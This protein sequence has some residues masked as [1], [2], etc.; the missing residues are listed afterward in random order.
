MDCMGTVLRGSWGAGCWCMFPRLAGEAQ[1]IG[2][3]GRRAAMTALAR[4]RRAPGL[5]AFDGDEAVGWI[6]I[7]PR[8][9]YRRIEASRATPRVDE[10]DVWVIP[11]IT[12]RPSARG[13]GI[14][15]ALIR[16]AVAYAKAQGAP[17]L[18][19]YPR[20]G[21]ARTRDDNAYFGT[22]PLFRR[23][24]FQLIRRPL[25]SQRNFVPRVT[26]RKSLKS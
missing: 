6:A 8:T 13:R 5:L 11:C 20:A 4:R 15:L 16:A 2:S 3:K 17:A 18:E 25:K 7:A 12:V 19:A 24:G 22:E 26:F 14:A 10:V 21:S 23:A 1:R 9:E